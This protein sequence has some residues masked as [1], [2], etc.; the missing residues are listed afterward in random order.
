MA[1][2]LA[3]TLMVL[4]ADEGLALIESLP[5]TEAALLLFDGGDF[6]LRTTAGMDDRVEVVS[7]RVK[8]SGG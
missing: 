5:D 2:G 1:D 3:T 7:P 4:P 6:Q 8:R